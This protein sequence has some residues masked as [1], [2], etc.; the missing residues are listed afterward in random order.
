MFVSGADPNLTGDV[1]EL[2][3]AA[4]AARLGIPVLRPMTEHERYDLV[5]EIAG[6]FNGFSASPRGRNGDIVRSSS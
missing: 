5:F 2:K 4:E 6:E 3:I 1:A